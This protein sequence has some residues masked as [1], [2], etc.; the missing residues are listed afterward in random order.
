MVSLSKILP[1]DRLSGY[2]KNAGL[3]FASSMIVAII[4]LLLNP[5]LAKN[6]SPEDYAVLGY[7]ASFNLLLMPLLHGC[8]L[9][10]YTRQYYFTEESK[11]DV[12]GDTIL[13]S[14][15][16]IG[17]VSCL[18]FTG[19][20]YIFHRISGNSFPFFPY[21]VLTFVQLYVSNNVNFYLAK[22]RITRMA[23]TYA[24]FSILQCVVT[25]AL[26][27]L[28]VVY[29]KTGAQGKLY[30]ALV[31]TLIFAAFAVKQ[32]LV[33][34]RV[35]KKI[36]VEALKFGFPLTIS[37]LFWYCLTGVDRLFLE[38]LGDTETFGIYNVGFAIAAYMQIFHTTIS[39]TFEPDIYQS[40]SENNKKKLYL[41]IGSTTAIIVVANMV[42]AILA[43]FLIDILTAGRYV[44]STPFARIFALQNIAMAFYYTVVR[45]IVGYGYVKGELLVRIVGAVCSVGCFYLL[46]KSH[47]FYGA[48]WGQVLSFTMLTVLGI[49]YLV[50]KT[51]KNN[52]KE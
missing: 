46:I 14:M 51:A 36:L 8:V 48:A 5:I 27:L 13:L 28:L 40:I 6:L 7:Y 49:V 34:W 22:L 20:F 47:G 44:D 21:A 18:L 33:K 19:I 24:W 37:A 16:V 9:T 3:Y 23:K 38:K 15:N 45:L 25:N 1:L 26:V 39:N 12:L 30:A 32:S 17:A 2:I 42:F 50:F 29:Y 35:D 41:I 10:Y 4:G 52:S 31:A 11:R 43:P